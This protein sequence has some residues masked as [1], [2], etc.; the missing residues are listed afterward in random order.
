MIRFFVCKDV[1]ILINNKLD[2]LNNTHSNLNESLT[3][4]LF[5]YSYSIFESALT[6]ILRYY[7]MAFPE[8]MDRTLTVGK[9]ELLSTASTHD[10]ILNSVNK[11]IRKFSSETLCE[12][13]SFFNNTLSL[14]LIFDGNLINII[15]HVRNNI[16]H[17]DANSELLFLH[18][19]QKSTSL[20]YI[21][22]EKYMTYLKDLL[23]NI[24][25][26][27]NKNYA[28]YTYELLLRNIWSYTFSTPLLKFDD[29]WEFRP[30][31]ILHIKDI[32]QIKKNISGICSSEQLLLSVFFHQYN[33][34]LN[35][36]FLSFKDIPPLVSLDNI[37]KNKLMEIITFFKY[38]PLIFNG[39]NIK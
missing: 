35:D 31:G 29:I 27:I 28:K 15:S 12:Y 34:S 33:K 36:T 22:V 13:I 39:M 23:N 16:T 24:Q 25:L 9:D 5:L 3:K 30:D 8:K 10:I 18:C 19:E 17:D 6:E 37:N 38:Y 2:E 14:N 20:Q 32:N 1:D 11:Y 4:P 7:L 21:D 26:E